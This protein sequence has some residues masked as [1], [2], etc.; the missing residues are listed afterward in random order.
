[1]TTYTNM[2]K[3]IRVSGYTSCSL[4]H[5][6]HFRNIHQTPTRVSATSVL[7]LRCRS[8]TQIIAKSVRS[9]P[10][11]ASTTG[12]DA[13]MTA[14][15]HWCDGGHRSVTQPPLVCLLLL[16]FAA[17]PRGEAPLAP[18]VVVGHSSACFCS[19]NMQQDSCL[20][21]PPFPASKPLLHRVSS[22]VTRPLAPA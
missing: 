6:A 17:L 11:F 5:L 2:L 7:H 4:Q 3:Y 13:A 10:K 21:S 16:A 8:H 12:R 15:D 18:G 9:T 22:S 20:Q 14:E 19:M 1:M